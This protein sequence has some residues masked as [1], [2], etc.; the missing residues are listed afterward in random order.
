MLDSAEM[1]HMQLLVK[2]TWLAFTNLPVH[3]CS[4]GSS[5]YS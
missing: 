5:I 2:N 4:A 3:D 1:M